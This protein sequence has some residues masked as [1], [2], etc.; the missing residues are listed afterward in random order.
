[1]A[2]PPPGPAGGRA[3][4]RGGRTGGAGGRRRG[5][6]VPLAAM[7][8]AGLL[9]LGLLALAG[10]MAGGPRSSL[11]LGQ[12]GQLYFN[13]GGA[14]GAR[15]GGEAGA[16]AAGE[17]GAGGVSAP[18]AGPP[19]PPQYAKVKKPKREKGKV[20][21]VRRVGKVGLKAAAEEVLREIWV[22][23]TQRWRQKVTRIL[24]NERDPFVDSRK[25]KGFLD[26]VDLPP[27][28]LFG[29]F[30]SCAVVGNAGSV[31]QS[32]YGAA[33]D[34]HSTVIRFN[35]AP[36]EGFEKHVG[37]KTDFRL[38]NKHWARKW[39][40]KAPEG[41]RQKALLVHVADVKGKKFL[42]SKL[43]TKMHAVAPEYERL[44]KRA[45]DRAQDVMEALG[46]LKVEGGHA[47]PSGVEGVFLGLEMCRKVNL[48]GFA[49]RG[50]GG[51][52]DL[53]PKGQK[54]PYRYFDDF[55]AAA[56]THAPGFQSEFLKV[57]EQ[58]GFV[59]L[60]SPGRPTAACLMKPPEPPLPPPPPPQ[61]PLPQAP[62][63]AEPA[64]PPVSQVEGAEEGVGPGGE[65]GPGA[66]RDGESEEPSG[67]GPEEA[68]R[69]RT[70]GE[71]EGEGEGGEG[72]G[73]ARR[74]L[75]ARGRR[76]GGGGGLLPSR[77]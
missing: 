8:A 26:N 32:D 60:C 21:V 35:N 15:A 6:L 65:G 74:A 42:R 50:F 55:P 13:P 44:A 24:L 43:G 77:S 54:M 27:K 5:R 53:A 66:T 7:G 63:D 56:S 62:P 72:A 12:L 23:G 30:E 33:I 48:F 28:D 22:P 69:G 39:M 19:P 16:G 1:M 34:R 29:A 73:G 76:G 49:V 45:Y 58:G 64:P 17:S 20:A 36:T 71:G 57:L 67:T 40:A 4:G 75:S 31:L 52:D 14:A 10:E 46:Y 47:T 70:E 61:A 37:R 18:G 41:C 38:L 59:G 3:G 9:L 51:T 2:P 25:R 11:T 68:E